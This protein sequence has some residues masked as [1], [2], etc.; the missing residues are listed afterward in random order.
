[1]RLRNTKSWIKYKLARQIDADLQLSRNDPSI[2][3][4]G[5]QD[6][7]FVYDLLHRHGVDYRLLLD[8][9]GMHFLA[10]GCEEF[11]PY[12]DVA[13]LTVPSG[14]VST[15]PRPIVEGRLETHQGRRVRFVTAVSDAARFD[16]LH[17]VGLV[18][19]VRRDQDAERHAPNPAPSV[20][21][22]LLGS[23]GAK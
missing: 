23:E 18:Q 12:E 8:A 6:V 15:W 13:L 1:M 4:D 16:C 20:R 14:P 11:V 19:A 22:E 3:I 7:L 9:H 21:Q 17:W 5:L 2:R 10:D